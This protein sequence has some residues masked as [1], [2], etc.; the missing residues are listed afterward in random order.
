MQQRVFISYSRRNKNFAERI[1]RDLDDAGLD[2]WVDFRQI[3]GGEP[4]QEEIFRGIERADF[5]VACLSPPAVQSVWVK[6]EILTAREQGK[7][8]IPVMVVRALDELRADE[9]LIWLTDIHIIN[10]EKGYEETF[11]ELLEALPGRRAIGAYDLFDPEN[12]P[13]PFKGLQSFQQ[14]D[15]DFF[16]GRETLIDKAL[17]RLQTTRFLGVVGAS[18][19]GKSSLVRAGII[20]KL[21][22][23]ALDGSEKWLMAIFKPGN[24]PIES[25]AKRILPVIPEEH[26]ETYNLNTL[27]ATFRQPERVIDLMEQIWADR[28]E[29]TRIL[30]VID[31]FEEVFTRASE[32]ER[33]PFLKTMLVAATSPKSRAKI[34]ITMRADF[35][36]NL[37]RYPELAELFEQRNLLI[38]TEMTTANL[39]RVIEGP[40]KA[41]GLQYEHGLVDRILEDVQS[42]PGSLPLLQY[43]L[44][45]LYEQRDGVN[46][47]N[48]AYDAIGGV[49]QAL[50][51]HAENIFSELPPL[52]QDLTRRI[53]LRLVEVNDVGEATRRRV[54]RDE[55]Q[56]RDVPDGDVDRIVDLLTSAESRLLIASRE[57]TSSEQE[58]EPVTW[59]EVSHEALIRE[60][61]RFKTWV[62]ASLENLQYNSELLKSAHDW[63]E[64]GQDSAYLLVG[65][66]L[67]RAEIWIETTDANPL[68]QA[69]IEAS[70]QSQE[71]REER[72]REQQERELALQQTSARRLRGIVALLI[73][74]IVIAGI[75]IIA[76]IQTNTALQQTTNELEEQSIALEQALSESQSLAVSASADRA[77]DDNDGDLAIALALEAV[78]VPNPPVQAVNNVQ[79]IVLAPGTHRAMTVDN[80]DEIVSVALNPDSS[81]LVTGMESGVLIVWDVANASEIQRFNAHDDTVNDL[82]FSVDGL[83]MLSASD[84]DENN[85]LLWSTPDWRMISPLVGHTDSVNS[86]A[87]TSNLQFALS[88]GEDR[89]FIMWDLSTYEMAFQSTH[90]TA[91]NAVAGSPNPDNDFV[92]SG[93]RDG[94]IQIRSVSPGAIGDV[95][96][97]AIDVKLDTFDSRITGLAFSPDGLKIGAGFGN[98]GLGIWETVTGELDIDFESIGSAIT[99]VGFLFGDEEIVASARDG[100]I[101]A[102]DTFAGI[103]LRNFIRESAVLDITTVIDTSRVAT[104]TESEI[105]VWDFAGS[106][107]LVVYTGHENVVTAA[108]FSPDEKFIVSGSLDDSL[109]L[110]D[111]ETGDPVQF[112]D[113]HTGSIAD[114]DFLPDGTQIISASVDRTLILWDVESGKILR[115]YEGH[116]GNISSLDVS[117]DGTQVLSG[118]FDSQMIL[119]NVATGDIIRRFNGHSDTV[120]SVVFSPDG[121][122]ALSGSF[123]N[124]IILWDVTTGDILRTLTGHSDSVTAV[125]FNDDGTLAVSGASDNTVRIWD[126]ASGQEIRRLEGHDRGVNDVTFVPNTDTVLSTSSDGTLRLWDIRAGAELHS[127]TVENNIG[128]A[129][130]IRPVDI[131]STGQFAVTGLNDDTLSLWQVLPTVD[132]LLEWTLDNRHVRDLSC[133]ERLV[134]GLD[135]GDTS[136]EQI[137][138]EASRLDVHMRANAES[139]IIGQ[140]MNGESVRV[141][142]QSENENWRKVCTSDGLTGW[143]T[144]QE[145]FSAQSS[146]YFSR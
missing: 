78:R 47:T 48:A 27:M 90:L 51:R 46:L 64:S 113:G 75:G 53:L 112:F 10:F 45:Q 121:T 81:I 98:G 22:K 74:G 102:W 62:N 109:I 104:V 133:N 100:S 60:W 44:S 101:R 95:L 71:E 141:L 103:Q 140:I 128:R 35:F 54:P 63:Q 118:G 37:S 107:E 72:Q 97:I 8:I 30:I 39:L 120:L 99:A 134:F 12:I 16:F 26:Q 56:F 2:V 14:T 79:Q 125:G 61:E 40:A 5:I 66:R 114:V 77:L 127:Y 42:E 129:V 59:L 146:D 115:I 143:V 123:D 11:P 137:V 116:T 9:E 17:N 139:E 94:E 135:E 29:Q 84:G 76:M 13:N 85:L 21:R 15:A 55:L 1:A 83:W 142:S 87:F 50:A 126:L 3:Q 131:D 91:V 67:N 49:Q 92:A 130:A 43:A 80:G 122:R 110:W 31:Q 33:V 6:K 106:E 41:V 136:F 89:Q 57:I 28:T 70:L 111:T 65:K 25:L 24:K 138:V 4:W 7:L 144:T 32:S 82:A 58:I 36:G 18:G 88:G 108:E 145:I 23:G 19:S 96:D 132:I 69:F 124:S 117:P 93:S 20:P 73:V 105:R 68:Q 119:W 52:Q 34:I 86:V 38:V